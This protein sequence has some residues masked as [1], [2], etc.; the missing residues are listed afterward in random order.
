MVKVKPKVAFV[1]GLLEVGLFVLAL[2]FFLGGA[3]SVSLKA[4]KMTP[5]ETF[6]SIR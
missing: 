6:V 5:Q 3:P 1:L 4:F 2:V